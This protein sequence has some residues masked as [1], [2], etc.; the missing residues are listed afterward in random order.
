M[1]AVGSDISD[2]MLGRAFDMW[3]GMRG[4][5]WAGEGEWG[6]LRMKMEV[7]LCF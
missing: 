2:E 7:R 3:V 4:D 6:L 1:S 5:V